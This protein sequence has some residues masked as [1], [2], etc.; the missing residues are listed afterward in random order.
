LPARRLTDYAGTYR[1]PWYGDIVV[2]AGKE[3][4]TLHLTR[5]K[6]LKGPLVPWNGETF[7]A[8]WPDRSLD[9]DALVTF[10][11]DGAGKISGM[12]LVA[13]SD[14]TDFSYDYHH[15]APMRAAK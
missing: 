5:S 12:K 3:G 9:A 8:R 7:L 13:A 1:D 2:S 10:T 15:L 14:R 4:L 6:L 11:T